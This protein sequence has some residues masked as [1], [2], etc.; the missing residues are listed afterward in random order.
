LRHTPFAFPEPEPGVALS[1]PTAGRTVHVQAFDGYDF[2]DPRLALFLRSGAETASGAVVSVHAAMRNPAVYRAVTLISFAIGMLPCHLMKDGP[3]G[4]EKASDHPLFRVLHREPNNW[5]SAF[6]FRSLL[7]LRALVH[8]NGYAQVVRS[9]GNVLALNPLDSEK[10]TPFQRPDLSVAY[11]YRRP[12]GVEITLEPSEVFHLRGATL[13]GINGLSMVRQAAEA[14]GL[15]LQAQRATARVYKN[16][17]FNSAPLSTEKG[18]SDTAYNRLK[19]DWQDRYGGADN[20]G[21]TPI[22]E[23]GLKPVNVGQSARDAQFIETQRHQI[24]EIARASGVPRPLLMMD[25]TTW[26][27]GIEA[28]GLFFVTYALQ[29]WFTA[30]E[31]AIERTLLTG[32]EKDTHSAKFNA[33]ALLRGSLK[34][35]GEFFA[36]AL[37][38]GGHDP[39]MTQDEV[40]KLADQPTRGGAADELSKGAMSAKGGPDAEPA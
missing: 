24:E 37:G 5:Q 11:K 15:G 3:N 25:E 33:G 38:S 35:Q 39:W 19:E 8:G 12:D 40:R 6:D 30:W 18:L 21:K 36:K 10:V 27:T 22:L 28:L 16:G 13:D 14:I 31:Q 34:D 7:Q 26:G 29:P 4:A 1:T 2:N 23:E 20:A 9:R 32:R 17:S